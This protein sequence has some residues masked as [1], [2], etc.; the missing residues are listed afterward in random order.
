M[1]ILL[2]LFLTMWIIVVILFAMSCSAQTLDTPTEDLTKG[3][4]PSDVSQESSDAYLP[5]SIRIK[6]YADCTKDEFIK[7]VNHVCLQVSFNYPKQWKAE[8]GSFYNKDVITMVACKTIYKVDDSID[9]YDFYHNPVDVKS[10]YDFSN[11]ICLLG[12]TSNGTPYIF[13][14][15]E[16]SYAGCVAFKFDD[17]LYFLHIEEP[18]DSTTFYEIVNSVKLEQVNT[19]TD[20]SIELKKF[21]IPFEFMDNVKLTE[22]DTYKADITLPSHWKSENPLADEDGIVF[23]G[24]TSLYKID[25]NYKFTDSSWKDFRQ[26]DW[27]FD[28]MI[29][30][31]GVTANGYEYVTYKAPDNETYFCYIKVIP[32]Y[33]SDFSIHLDGIYDTTI[34]EVLDSINFYK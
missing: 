23:L 9:I 8:D 4:N 25:D 15:N 16:D 12:A 22:S 14:K 10:N 18:I 3:V 32:G 34:N 5:A 27:D 30:S 19:P 26:I 24:F 31:T 11:K 2:R 7:E 20:K 1:K 17:Y 28:S 6:T 21:T 29:P 13:C 33:A